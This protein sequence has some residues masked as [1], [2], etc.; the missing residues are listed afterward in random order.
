[1]GYNQEQSGV[2]G[3]KGNDEINHV[4]SGGVQRLRND[5]AQNESQA[6][7]KQGIQSRHGFLMHL[8]YSRFANDAIK[9]IRHN[10]HFKHQRFGGDKQK[11]HQRNLFHFRKSEEKQQQT[12]GSDKIGINT[13]PFG[14]AKINQR[15][16]K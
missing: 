12:L 15:Y 16:G 5:D 6:H 2:D 7:K 14:Y 8:F 11:I 4:D 13:E 1:V 3:K 10:Q 9:Q